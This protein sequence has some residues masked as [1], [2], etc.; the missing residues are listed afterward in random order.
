[1][2]IKSIFGHWAVPVTTQAGAYT[3]QTRD[4]GSCIQANGALTATLPAPGPELNGAWVQFFSIAA[5]DM[6]ITSAAADTLVVDADAAADS[7]T[8]G[9]A[10]EEIGASVLALCDGTGWLIF[11]DLSGVTSSKAVAT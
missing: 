8:F 4:F 5:G 3:V 7:I 6:V 1:M 10:G 11:N 9:T 2:P